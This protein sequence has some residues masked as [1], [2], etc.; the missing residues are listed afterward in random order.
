MPGFDT[1][2]TLRAILATGH[3]YSW[4]VM[5]QKILKKEVA[6]S[7]S[8]Q[9]P[10]FASRSWLKV[11]RQRL[12]NNQA[13]PAVEAFKQHGEDFIVANSLEDLV[14][15]MNRKGGDLIDLEK[16]RSQIVRARQPDRQ[17]LHQGC[18]IDGGACGAQLSWRPIDA[19][20]EAAPPA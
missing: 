1:L 3:D 9:N 14:D 15:G 7:G 6:L 20:G 18:A 2:S 4:F 12:L 11:I 16:L 19:D 10:D 5:T 8:E 17:P 13:T